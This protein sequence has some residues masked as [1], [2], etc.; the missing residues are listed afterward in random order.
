M[1]RGGLRER[2]NRRVSP[3]GLRSTESPCDRRAA[4]APLHA[5]A[6]PLSALQENAPMS[7]RVTSPSSSVP[8]HPPNTYI[9]RSCASITAGCALRRPGVWG[10]LG[11]PAASEPTF[12]QRMLTVSR[13]CTARKRPASSLPP[14]S[15]SSSPDMQ[16]VWHSRRVGALTSRS[17][18]WKKAIRKRARLGRSPRAACLSTEKGQRL[19][20]GVVLVCHP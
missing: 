12:S 19:G 11:V 17:L 5:S 2:E 3:G 1:Q 14:K 8:F 6:A 10:S 20:L 13:M 9:Q 4:L 7:K 18:N 16:M 15:T